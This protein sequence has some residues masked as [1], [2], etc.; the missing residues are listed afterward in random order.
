MRIEN[1]PQ[2]AKFKSALDGVPETSAHAANKDFFRELPDKFIRIFERTLKEAVLD[3]WRD[4]KGV[5][6]L[7]G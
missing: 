4:E 2:F 7:G 1:Y 5:D 6:M 3:K